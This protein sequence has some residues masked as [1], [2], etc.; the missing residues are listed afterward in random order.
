[1]LNLS[2]SVPHC[3][4]F[5][6]SQAAGQKDVDAMLAEANALLN[7]VAG[8]ATES[9]P[10]PGVQESIDELQALGFVCDE[11][12]CVLVLPDGTSSDDEG[13]SPGPAQP[14]EVA[15]R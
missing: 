9:R 2:P 3:P 4:S 14:S 8:G 12:G 11:S 5:L 6:A 1:V 7:A 13:E 15:A 10:V